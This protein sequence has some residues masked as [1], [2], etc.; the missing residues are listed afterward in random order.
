ML[1]GLHIFDKILTFFLII[2]LEI[3]QIH[4]N[5]R[6]NKCPFFD[7]QLR[8]AYSHIL[9]Y[10]SKAILKIKCLIHLRIKIFANEP[11]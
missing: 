1:K 5:Y 9:Q 8:I 4:Q 10:P 7:R 3:R 11:I 6:S 2:P